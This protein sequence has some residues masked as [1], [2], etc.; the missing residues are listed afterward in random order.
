MNALNVKIGIM[1]KSL[2]IGGR[3]RMKENEISDIRND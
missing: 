1:I 2:L 3:Y